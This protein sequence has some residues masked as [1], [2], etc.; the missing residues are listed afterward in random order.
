A[1]GVGSLAVDLRGHHDSQKGPA[2]T[3]TFE[4]FD[5]TGEWPRAVEDL[6]TAARWLR[7]RGVPENRIAFGGASIGA[8]LASLAA[9]AHPRAPFLL[10][11]SPGPDYRGV[12]LKARPGLKTLVG[13]SPGDRYAHQTLAPLSAVQGV[14]T[15]E[16]PGGHGTQMFEDKATLDRV[17]AWT[18]A[19][20]RGR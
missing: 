13:A 3:R 14:E 11:L 7:K 5:A 12:G 9:A 20:S 17:V 18:V 1:A 15:F 10:L 6:E 4:D 19:A 2:G 16:A 8:N